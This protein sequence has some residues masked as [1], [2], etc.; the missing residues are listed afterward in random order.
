MSSSNNVFVFPKE[1][2]RL[3]TQKTYEEVTHNIELMNHFHVQET[4]TN[5][6]PMLFNQLEIAGFNLGEEAF[7]DVKDGALMVEA[8]RSLLCKNL[9]LYH[10]FQTVAQEIFEDEPDDPTALRIVDRLDL[11]LTKTSV[12]A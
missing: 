10:P 2:K 4:I 8:L 12:E 3:Q 11:S 6:L 9:D 1:N 7:A 5:L